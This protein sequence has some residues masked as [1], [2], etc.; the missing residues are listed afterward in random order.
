MAV[1]STG[2]RSGRFSLTLKMTSRAPSA[3]ATATESASIDRDNFERM[4][5]WFNTLMRDTTG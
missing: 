2:I 5:I 3:P 4:G 1:S